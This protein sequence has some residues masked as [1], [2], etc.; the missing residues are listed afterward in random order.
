MD[1]ANATKSGKVIVTAS[2]LFLVALV[3]IVLLYFLAPWPGL[4]MIYSIT[5]PLRGHPDSRHGT[6]PSKFVGL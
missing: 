1:G 4:G 3:S 5:D 6:Q 2:R